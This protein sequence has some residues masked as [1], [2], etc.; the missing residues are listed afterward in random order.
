[1]LLSWKLPELKPFEMPSSFL[2]EAASDGGES[3]ILIRF[4][5]LGCRD[6]KKRKASAQNFKLMLVANRQV[7]V[8]RVVVGRA[9]ELIGVFNGSMCRLNSLLREWDVAARDRVQVV[10]GNLGVHD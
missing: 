4:F 8:G 3:P 1:M 6:A 2:R 9:T 7:D 5:E 10:L